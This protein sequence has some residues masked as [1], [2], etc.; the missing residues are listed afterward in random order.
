[1]KKGQKRN[2]CFIVVWFG[3][4]SGMQGMAQSTYITKQLPLESK[5]AFE[6]PGL[7]KPGR[8]SGIGSIG[9]YQHIL[10]AATQVDRMNWKLL[11]ADYYTR[12]FGFFCKRELEVEKKLHLPLKFRLGSLEY[13]NYLE[14][15]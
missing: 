5:L 2:I 11:P 7:I 3:F 8:G 15:K 14:G 13:C 9:L 1:M 4:I 6:V 12:D 10:P